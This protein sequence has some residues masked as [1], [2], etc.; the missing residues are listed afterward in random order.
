MEEA[1]WLRQ[2]WFLC[3]EFKKIKGELIYGRN[4]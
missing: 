2:S 3:K 4:Y 1:E